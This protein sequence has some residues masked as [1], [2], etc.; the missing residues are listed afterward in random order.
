MTASDRTWIDACAAFVGEHGVDADELVAVLRAFDAPFPRGGPPPPPEQRWAASFEALEQA[1]GAA[2]MIDAIVH[3]LANDVD[4]GQAELF[5]RRVLAVDGFLSA[6]DDPTARVLRV[7]LRHRLAGIL[8]ATRPHATRVRALADFYYSHGCRHRH[9]VGATR[10]LPELSAAVAR[11]QWRAVCDGLEHAEIDGRFAEGP[12]HV[13]LLRVDPRRIALEVADLRDAAHAGVPFAT[14]VAHAGAIA[15]TSG[16]FFLYS[17]PDIAAPSRRHDPVGLVV[18]D[19]EVVAPPV[20]A[21]GALWLDADGRAELEPIGLADVVARSRRGWERTLGGAIHR[22]HAE[23]GPDVPSFAVV[24]RAVVA[25]GTQL[26]V[27]LNGF[28]VAQDGLDV[29][30]GE[31]LTYAI[32]RRP[33]PHCAIAGGPMLV[34][35]GAPVLLLRREDFWG[36]APPVTFSQDETGDHNLLPR[37][38]VGLQG[39][40][41]VFAAVDGRNLDRALG[42]TLGE[43]AGLFVALGCERAVNLDGGSSKRMLVQGRTLDLPSTE[44]VGEVALDPSVRPVYSAILMRPRPR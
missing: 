28:V 4:R 27:P 1:V 34:E 24:G 37:L 33:T 18:R 9:R 36:S 40:S 22:A 41:L 39:G 43:L 14:S 3:D 31:V 15:A 42:M 35:S 13:N 2:P 7:G 23:R 16:G 12:T 44:V 19:G 10:D 38:G 21:R 29:E 5:A 6:H 20:F 8:A 11:V 26:S 25:V 17:E 32:D 30:V